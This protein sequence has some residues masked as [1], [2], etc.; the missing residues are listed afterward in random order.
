MTESPVTITHEGAIARA[1][2]KTDDLGELTRFWL[3]MGLYF[4]QRMAADL[5]V[6]YLQRI[7][8][9][10]LVRE[11]RD[12]NDDFIERYSHATGRGAYVFEATPLAAMARHFIMHI[13]ARRWPHVQLREF[14]NEA[15]AIRWLEELLD[16]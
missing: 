11:A 4:D 5:P 1:V 8:E 14:D 2:T 12:R 9:L 16:E 15:D 10:M 6:L 3:E 13:L 7:G